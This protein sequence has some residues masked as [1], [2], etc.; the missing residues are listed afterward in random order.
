M[1][2]NVAKDAFH[3]LERT[4]LEKEVELV[5]EKFQQDKDKRVLAY[6]YYNGV[7]IGRHMVADGL[8]I[9]FT[10]Y[11]F[12]R[13]DEYLNSENKAI[14]AKKGLWNVPAAAE[15]SLMLKKIWQKGTNN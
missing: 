7:D 10:R 2:E 12:P 13:M 4:I 1:L 6:V 3:Y 15:R 14:R 8:S 9:V 11:P 5:F